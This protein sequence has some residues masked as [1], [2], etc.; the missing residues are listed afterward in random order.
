MS[1]HYRNDAS[2]I[3]GTISVRC[4]KSLHS[5]RLLPEEMCL[6][7]T[8]GRHCQSFD[9]ASGWPETQIRGAPIF[10]CWLRVFT[11]GRTGRAGRI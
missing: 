3:P 4:A 11:D 7:V 10:G 8:W 6:G 1:D 9:S 5:E 2:G